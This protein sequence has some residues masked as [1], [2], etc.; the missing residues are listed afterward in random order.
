MN[1]KVGDLVK[2]VIDYEIETRDGSKFNPKGRYGIVTTVHKEKYSAMG[3][4]KYDCC[5]EIQ[6]MPHKLLW[7]MS[8]EVEIIE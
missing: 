3:D 1:I 7:F 2:V 5:V 6:G 8:E 4:I